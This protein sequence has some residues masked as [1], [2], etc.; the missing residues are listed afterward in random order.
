M[1]YTEVNLLSSHFCI[2]IRGNFIQCYTVQFIFYKAVFKKILMIKDIDENF[3]NLNYFYCLRKSHEKIFTNGIL[4]YLI[5]CR[6]LI[7]IL[8]QRYLSKREFISNG[9]TFIGL[10]YCF[11]KSRWDEKKL[12]NY[13]CILKLKYL[14]NYLSYWGMTS[15]IGPKFK[16]FSG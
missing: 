1:D 13:L 16:M 14:L 7:V 15:R 10:N 5:L 2:N 3:L 12:M 4:T 6:I 11:C 9:N 8:R